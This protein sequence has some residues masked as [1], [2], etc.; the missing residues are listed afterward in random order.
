MKQ[1]KC[2]H[3]QFSGG[4]CKYGPGEDWKTTRNAS[5]TWNLSSQ[6]PYD[7]ASGL[8]FSQEKRIVFKIVKVAGISHPSDRKC[9]MAG[10]ALMAQVEGTMQFATE[11]N[12]ESSQG[13]AGKQNFVQW[14][15]SKW[16]RC[17]Q[18][19]IWRTNVWNCDETNFICHE[20]C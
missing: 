3:K 2:L 15:W 14:F 10:L 20:V 18:N 4:F 6:L 16:R 13:R 17:W 12:T 5:R 1:S 7:L 11:D 9:Q 19:C 8:T